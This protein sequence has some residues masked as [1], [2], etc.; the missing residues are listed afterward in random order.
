MG[1]WVACTV[2]VLIG[3]GVSVGAQA[4]I[5]NVAWMQGCWQQ[6]SGDRVIEENWTTPLA[7][8]MLGTGRTVRAGKLVDHEFVVLVERDG[9]LVYEAYPSAQLPTT[10]VSKEINVGSIVFE[11][12]AHDFPQRVGYRRV[13][14]DRITAWIEGTV[15][16]KTRR[17]EFSYR[18]VE[19]PR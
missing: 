2:A 15:G 10:F 4:G 17:Q 8:A 18:R 6:K 13:A 12:P 16:G 7:G 5:D 1:R 19:C 3:S 9:R 11:D 14:A